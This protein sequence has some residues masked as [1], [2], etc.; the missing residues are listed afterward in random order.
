LQSAASDFII[1]SSD[2]NIDM[3]VVMEHKEV[4]V[5]M[6]VG[7]E[8]Q[9]VVPVGVELQEVEVVMKVRPEFEHHK[10]PYKLTQFSLVM[11]Q[12]L[13]GQSSDHSAPDLLQHH[14]L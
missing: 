6:E 5:V 3:E 14:M 4:G 9:E 13:N 1:S 12:T 8:L 11:L 7:V 10:H 2:N